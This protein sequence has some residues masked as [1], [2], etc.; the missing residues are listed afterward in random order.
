MQSESVETS[1]K[2]EKD[3]KPHSKRWVWPAGCT[4]RKCSYK[5]F[6]LCVLA[7][8]SY[9]LTTSW[10][11]QPLSEVSVRWSMSVR[12]EHV[13]EVGAYQW[14]ERMT[15]RCQSVLGSGCVTCKDSL[16]N[17]FTVWCNETD[18]YHLVV[19]EWLHRQ[20]GDNNNCLDIGSNT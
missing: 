7:R 5:L 20:K 8:A 12:W 16:T 1:K 14:G 10:W 13:R 4:Y 6:I 15:W 2:E 18:T 3:P 9:K 11:L 17:Q 19:V